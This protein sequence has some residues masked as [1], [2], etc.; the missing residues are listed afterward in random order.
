MR[1]A[2]RGSRPGQGGQAT[3]KA[4]PGATAWPQ[5]VSASAPRRD[6]PHPPPSDV[7][8]DPA[9]TV[10]SAGPG[11]AEPEARAA[12]FLTWR[13]RVYAEVTRGGVGEH[14]GVGQRAGVQ[15]DH[16]GVVALR[17][18]RAARGVCGP[19]A[20]G[21]VAVVASIASSRVM[22]SLTAAGARR[23]SSP[24]SSAGPGRSGRC[25]CP[26]RSWP[27]R[28][29]ARHGPQPISAM[30]SP[31][32]T[33]SPSATCDAR[34]GAR[35]L[36]QD[37]DLHL[38]RLQDDQGVTVIDAIALGRDHLPHVRDHLRANLSHGD[39]CLCCLAGVAPPSGDASWLSGTYRSPR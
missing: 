17:E 32:W 6:R 33:T 34:D 38:H 21:P 24:T 16:V 11:G 10:R 36:G 19:G 9:L 31:S 20:T 15:G 5:P 14:A 3:P 37:R 25:R 28:V 22:P 29:G 13:P 18:L 27:L 39:S 30:R 23:R 8:V 1:P 4:S 35:L 2:C 12:A 26:S 7:I